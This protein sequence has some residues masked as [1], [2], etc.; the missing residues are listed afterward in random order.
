MFYTPENRD[1]DLLPH[2]PL[3]AIIAPRPIGWISSLNMDGV[4][5]LA[6]Y[7]F[8][9]AIGSNPPLLMFS[10]EGH[11]DSSRNAMEM[12][13]FV[14]NYVGQAVEAE[15]N[16]SSVPAP[17]GVSEFDHCG[18]ERAQSEIVSPP[19]VAR[20][21]AAL[22]CKTTEIIEPVDINGN[23]ASVVLV[24]GQVVGVHINENFIQ[25][26]RFDVNIA[27][28]VSRLGYLDFGHTSE[29]HELPRPRWQE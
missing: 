7:S 1:H 25:E 27:K 11:K 23:K 29:I 12:R 19:R 28:P 20:A 17:A 13:E 26:G 18:I 9:N 14:F 2:D 10:S 16:A 4:A 6:P 5:N 15:M 8:F 3:K 21:A 22:E 24:L